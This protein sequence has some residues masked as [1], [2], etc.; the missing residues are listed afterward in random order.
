[1]GAL[2]AVEEVF[3]AGGE[4]VGFAGVGN[5]VWDRGRSAVASGVHAV[6]LAE[7]GGGRGGEEDVPGG[8]GG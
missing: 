3:F 5:R 4:R 8:G 7:E 2:R 6:P 1:M